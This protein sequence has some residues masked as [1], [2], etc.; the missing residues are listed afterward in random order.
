MSINPSLK[1]S[2]KID[3]NLRNEGLSREMRLG[4]ARGVICRTR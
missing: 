3:I 1:A 2:K 4:K